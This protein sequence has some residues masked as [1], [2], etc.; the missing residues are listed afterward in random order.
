VC[1]RRGAGSTHPCH[2]G[3]PCDACVRLGYTDEQCETGDV[4]GGGGKHER[5]GRKRGKKAESGKA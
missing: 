5:P 2:C 4:G 3:P 1:V